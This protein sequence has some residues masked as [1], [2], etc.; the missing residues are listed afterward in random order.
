MSN[1]FIIGNGFDISLG[2]NTRYSDF[3]Q[4]EFWPFKGEILDLAGHLEKKKKTAKWLDIEKELLAYAKEPTGRAFLT[5]KLIDTE[6]QRK[7]TD[8][9]TY[10]QLCLSL[11]KYLSIEQE[12]YINISSVAA[13]VLKAVIKNGKFE[14]VY[15]FNYTNLSKV[16]SVLGLN[17][18]NVHYVHGSLENQDIILG[19]DDHEDIKEGY[20][21]LYKTYNKYYTSTPLN[22]SLLEANEVV[23]F[24]HS[25]GETDYHY[26]SNFFKAQSMSTMKSID[27]K[28]IT[29]FTYND[30][31]RFEILRQLRKMNDGS[32]EYLYGNNNFQII[33][34]DG[35][36]EK[37]EVKLLEFENRMEENSINKENAVFASF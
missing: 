21:Y 18:V 22:F 19:V 6:I 9:A 15:S 7:E 13:R 3:A 36:D 26:L 27:K 16:I 35:K 34:T 2:W 32:L 20:D 11:F 29:I 1:V 37:D 23:I 8:L 4:S 17:N 33:C 5:Q 24:G 10:N 25:L 28:W 14:T 30:N 12:K 31:S